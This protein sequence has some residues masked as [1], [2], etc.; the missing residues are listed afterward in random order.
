[1]L[2]FPD[3]LP[4][5]A[6]A[7]AKPSGPQLPRVTVTSSPEDIRRA[8][9]SVGGGAGRSLGGSAAATPPAAGGSPAGSADDGSNQR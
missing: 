4:D 7:P 9:E 8:F 2:F 5:D 3:T 1:M 6:P